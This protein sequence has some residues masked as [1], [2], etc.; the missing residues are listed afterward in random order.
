MRPETGYKLPY[1]KKEREK[2]IID[3]VAGSFVI[4]R[5]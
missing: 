4:D 1:D 3:N 2:E 5:I